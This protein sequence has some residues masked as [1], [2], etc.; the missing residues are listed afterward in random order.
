MEHLSHAVSALTQYLQDLL[1]GFPDVPTRL[2]EHIKPLVDL[3]GESL[4]ITDL[5]YPD[6]GFTAPKDLPANTLAEF[7]VPIFV[8][9][10]RAEFQKSLLDWLRTKD[11][12]ALSNMRAAVVKVQ[13]VQLKATQK[14]L[15]WVATALMDALAQ[16]KV[17]ALSGAK[18]L[19]RRLDQQLRNMSEGDLKA[20]PQLLRDALYYV[21][22]SDKKTDTITNVKEVFEL[23]QVLPAG[24]MSGQ[25]SVA[26]DAERAALAQL[27]ADLPMLKDLWANISE[28]NQVGAD[29]TPFIS[30]FKHLTEVQ[31]SLN[32]QVVY[33]LVAAIHA[34]SNALSLDPAKVNEASFI[35][36]ASALNLLEYI[37][38]HYARLDV[39]AH[40]KITSQSARLLAVTEGV[41]L[42]P[43]VDAFANSAKLDTS[44]IDA[45]AK[46]ILAALQLVEKALDTFFRNPTEVAVLDDTTKPLQQIS[47]AFDMLEMPI[48]KSIAQLSTAYVAYFKDHAGYLENSNFELLAE[49]LSMLGLYAEE[50]P[51]TRAESEV[52]L[53]SAVKRL[54]QGAIAFDIVDQPKESDLSTPQVMEEVEE[55]HTVTHDTVPFP[56][57]DDMVILSEGSQAV[58]PDDV[59]DQAIDDELQEI[60]LTEAEE[61]LVSIAPV[62]YT[63]LDV[64][65]RQVHKQ[66]Y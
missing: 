52:A 22:V 2:Y 3:Q 31:Q 53:A 6:T 62:S 10:Q 39:E 56:I 47:A 17:A 46:Q 25:S 1:N 36:I 16:D 8:G 24:A 59:T 44:V 64:Y 42:A 4:E 32:N 38:E 45:V 63:H 66:Q 29:L 51:N 26:T 54:E 61:V 48:P 30:K 9:E 34:A 37:G 20:P 5:F 27:S 33:Q 50:L 43:S 12:T 65:K 41:P 11:V 28:N 18:K 23:D 14:T 7:A 57:P 60:F 19:C 49:S 21:A 35:E 58:S 13:Q 15:W 40:A 55:N